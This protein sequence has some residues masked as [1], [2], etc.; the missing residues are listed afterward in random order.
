VL[1]PRYL[2]LYQLIIDTRKA[3]G[4]PDLFIQYDFH[5]FEDQV[6]ASIT[7]LIARALRGGNCFDVRGIASIA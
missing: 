5:L 2:L 1:S 6:L 4:R 7:T 3:Q